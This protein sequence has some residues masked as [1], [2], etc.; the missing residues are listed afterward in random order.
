MLNMKI[1]AKINQNTVTLY[2]AV[3]KTLFEFN[4]DNEEPDEAMN[5]SP[6]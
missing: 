3:D 6:Y 1:F 2:H 4:V 5:S